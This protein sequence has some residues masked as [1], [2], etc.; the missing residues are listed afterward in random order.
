MAST[1]SVLTAIINLQDNV[2]KQVQDVQ[3]SFQQ[4]ST[5]VEGS[6]ES[7]QLFDTSIKD[8]DVDTGTLEG[9]VQKTT[10]IFGDF[11][12]F[13]KNVSSGVNDMVKGF[14]QLGGLLSGNTLFGQA[15]QGARDFSSTLQTIQAASGATNDQIGEV[16][17][18]LKDFAS[19]SKFTLD[20]TTAAFT[21]LSQSAVGPQKSM[22]I[23]NDVMKFGIVTGND[24]GSIVSTLTKL[25]NR[26]KIGTGEVNTT[27]NQMLK[28]S[29]DSKVDINS[30]GMF[31]QRLA[32]T[33]SNANVSFE[34]I[35]GSITTLVKNGAEGRIAMMGL[36]QV[37]GTLYSG[38][39]QVKEAFNKVNIQITDSNG[40]FL[41]FQQILDSVRNKLNET[42][43]GMALYGTAAEKSAL[44]N[45]LFGDGGERVVK[46]LLD[47]KNGLNEYILALKNVGDQV[48]ELA[49]KRLNGLGQSLKDLKDN[50]TILTTNLGA[51][52]IPIIKDVVKFL[53][54]LV[55]GWVS[56]TEKMGWFGELLNKIVIGF[57]GFVPLVGSLALGLAG[58]Q[59]VILAMGYSLPEA[60]IGVAALSKSIGALVI[61]LSA[62]AIG[63]YIVYKA[64]NIL[65][66]DVLHARQV[67]DTWTQTLTTG[68]ITVFKEVELSMAKVGLGIAKLFQKDNV[69]NVQRYVDTLQNEVDALNKTTVGVIWANNAKKDEND[70]FAKTTAAAKKAID[71]NNDYADSQS[72]VQDE[73]S[74]TSESFKTLDGALSEIEKSFEKYKAIKDSELKTA[75]ALNKQ[76]IDADKKLY[77]QG[78]INLEQYTQDKIDITNTTTNEL[79]ALKQKEIEE[80]STDYTAENVVKIKQNEEEIKQLTIQNENDIVKI[81]D[82]SAKMQFENWKRSEDNKIVQTSNN[83]QKLTALDQEYLNNG[84]IT[85]EQFLADKAAREQQFLQQR[86]DSQTE[87]INQI[88][89]LEGS[90][91]E[92]YRKAVEDRT[93]LQNELQ[94]NITNSEQEIADFTMQKQTEATDFVKGLTGE[95]TESKQADYDKQLEQLDNYYNQGLIGAEDYTAAKEALDNKQVENSGK[96]AD[97]EIDLGNEVTDSYRDNFAK[98]TEFMDAESQAQIAAVDKA[99]AAMDQENAANAMGWAKLVADVKD[100]ASKLIPII[101]D[102]LGQSMEGSR[103]VGNQLRSYFSVSIGGFQDYI[104]RIR[105]EL[106]QSGMDLTQSTS[107]EAKEILGGLT[108]DMLRNLNVYGAKFADWVTKIKGLMNSLKE[109]IGGLQD[110]LDRMQ[111]NDIA[112]LE[113]EKE[114][115]IAKLKEQYGAD[116]SNTDEYKQALNLIN[117]IY[118][119][120]LSD[121]RDEERTNELQKEEDYQQASLD[122]TSNYYQSQNAAAGEFIDTQKNIFSSL[123]SESTSSLNTGSGA[124]GK[125]GVGGTTLNMD[126]GKELQVKPRNL[127]DVV[128]D[129]ITYQKN[130]LA[131]VNDA[132]NNTIRNL[133]EVEA[134]GIAVNR[135]IT[136]DVKTQ[137][138]SLDPNTMQRVT[139]EE[140][141]PEVI[142]QLKLRGTE[143]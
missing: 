20:Q 88:A 16:S 42:K 8:V 119:Q 98:Q 46:I 105:A 92:A 116:L 137:F 5:I 135:N 111:G 55:D 97:K 109:N 38:S 21:A 49:E 91:T 14:E 101:E 121:A 118:D 124:K 79:I 85:Q 115:K 94:N 132:T 59:K 39:E 75:E 120:K 12:G 67:I 90:N 139:R 54:V 26:F 86:I 133:K 74:K 112:I 6:S 30:L 100:T 113:R 127:G 84:I 65:I 72:G 134:G 2:S 136:I 60:S 131:G 57:T 76:F 122:N 10:S 62:V 102:T 71:S 28:V 64:L 107:A 82:D 106:A 140:I 69:A 43:D 78:K 25:M 126:F 7:M 53:K 73:T 40:N 87:T 93:T 56:L 13:L 24:Y 81:K 19:N 35:L 80:L 96:V 1:E 11:E 22:A 125:G 108:A 27:L 129:E 110:E 77:D 48:S 52:F 9:T 3:M 29:Q 58:V 50:W 61:E 18:F 34:Q 142:A 104:D 103:I 123:T 47:Q 63:S 114:D 51:S 143:A 66:D 37:F 15:V 138:D 99:S 89:T 4:L 23:L 44:L 128:N 130:L 33:T 45:Q 41:D 117:K 31:M 83:N 68:L 95:T 17:T 32:L 36:S 70:W 141:M